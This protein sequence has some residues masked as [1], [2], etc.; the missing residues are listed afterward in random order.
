MSRLKPLE[1]ARRSSKP[2]ATPISRSSSTRIVAGGK[3]FWVIRETAHDIHLAVRNNNEIGPKCWGV[4]GAAEVLAIIDLESGTDLSPIAPPLE[5]DAPDVPIEE[6]FV[7]VSAELVAEDEAL[8]DV[9]DP[10]VLAAIERHN[11]D[12]ARLSG[13]APVVATRTGALADAAHR[14]Y[15][16]G[17]ERKLLAQSVEEAR[18]S[19]PLTHARKSDGSLAAYADRASGYYNAGTLIACRIRPRAAT[20]DRR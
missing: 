20:T 18:A 3:E 14:R 12:A 6:T 16:A 11:A 19:A 9:T 8:E 15:L 10:S 5:A 4:G 2:E 17:L 13:E 7:P 1:S